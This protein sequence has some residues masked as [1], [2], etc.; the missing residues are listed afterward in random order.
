[1]DNL[2]YLT[3]AGTIVGSNYANTGAEWPT[4]NAY[5]SYG[6]SSNLWGTTWTVAE[7]NNSGFGARVS[8]IVQNGT[9]NIDHIRITVWYA[10]TLPIELQSFDAYPLNESVSIEWQTSAEINNDYF[11][12]E[13][14]QDTKS[15]EE[16]RNISGAGN[17]NQ[18]IYYSIMDNKPLSGLSYYRLKQTDYDGAFSYS[19]SVRVNFESKDGSVVLYP[20]PAQNYI[21]VKSKSDVIR[22]IIHDASGQILKE[23]NDCNGRLDIS[24]LNPGMYYVEVV[25]T[26]DSHYS[27]LY[28]S[29]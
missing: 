26:A 1:M 17:S 19:N 7:I 24:T 5:T 23:Y 2:V 22:V 25:N 29:K 16:I 4:A 3:K 12:V 20:K 18:L 8:A 9:A 21:S 14:S 6:G 10:S 15:W 11:T 27:K 13:R 28:V